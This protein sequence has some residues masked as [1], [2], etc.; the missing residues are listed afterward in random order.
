MTDRVLIIDDDENLLNGLRRQFHKRYRVSVAQGGEKA[1]SLARSHGPFAVAVCDMRM[2]GKDGIQVLGELKK[3]APETVRIMLTGNA[4]QQTAVDAVNKGDIF[5]FFNKPCPPEQLAAGID[6]AIEQFRLVTAERELLQKTLAG[7][8]KVLIDVL[9]MIDPDAFGK[10]TK[11]REWGRAMATQMMLPRA[12]QLDMGIMLSRIG[13]AAIP[14]EIQTKMKTGQDLTAMEQAMVSEIPETGKNWIANIP[15][16][17]PVA[18]IVYYQEKG[19]DGS[20]FPEDDCVGDAIPLEARVIKVLNDLAD[21]SPG[22][23]PGK[24]TFKLLAEQAEKYDPA[25]IDAAHACLVFSEGSTEA[26]KQEEVADIPVSLLMAG[27]RLLTDIETRCGQLVLAKNQ[28]VSEAQ[29]TKIKNLGMSLGI[30]EP[31]R[32]QKPASSPS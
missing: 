22:T 18:N 11:M 9:S 1:L 19:F 5:R 3:L 31:I 2:P 26:E 12:W 13:S 21:A 14:A 20:G 10:A 32:V 8:V 28:T 7:S 15:R 6:E 25:V 4:D 23:T 30:K 17:Q 29:L 24:A 27:Y 16:L